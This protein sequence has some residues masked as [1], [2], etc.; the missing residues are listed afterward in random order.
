MSGLLFYSL[1][2]LQH[3]LHD[4]APDHFMLMKPIPDRSAWPLGLNRTSMTAYIRTLVVKICKKTALHVLRSSVVK[5]SVRYIANQLDLK[6]KLRRY[7]LPGATAQEESSGVPDNPTMWR[8]VYGLDGGSVL[9][10][11]QHLSSLIGSLDV[12][13]A[14][15]GIDP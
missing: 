11:T 12:Y 10:R 4:S 14:S 1:L 3:H 5:K 7:L 2:L 13:S 8:S 9:P 15:A 6:E